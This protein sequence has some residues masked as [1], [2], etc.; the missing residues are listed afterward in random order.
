[1]IA[2][3][4]RAQLLSMRMGG[5][6]RA[7]SVVTGL[8]W[9]GVWVVAGCAVF[10][11]VSGASAD[12]LRLWLPLG[13]LG[14]CLYWQVMPILSASMGSALDMRKLMVYP[15]PHSK[16]FQ[17]EV[18][19]RLTTGVEM[20]MVLAGSVAGLFHRSPI[21]GCV[22]LPAVLL[23]IAFNLLL[24][25]GTRSLLERLLSMR[26]V[27][28][29]LVF[30]IFMVWMLPRFLFLTGHRPHLT[31]S[32][33]HLME[34]VAW[35]WTAAAW[36][37]LGHGELAALLSLGGWTL[38]A[39]WFGR[40][41]FERNLRFDAVAALATPQTNGASPVQAAAEAFYRFPARWLRDPLAA[42]V[43]KELRSLVRTPRYRMVFVMGFSFGLMIWLPMILGARADRNVTL[44]HHFLPVVS[45]YSLTLLGQVSFWNCFGFDR[46]AALIYFVAPQPLAKTFAGKNVAA[47]VFI[48]LEVFILAGVTSLFGVN[49]GVGQILETLLV[50]GICSL[51]MLA[52]GNI[53]S[54][55]YPRGLNP[56]RVSQGGASSRFQAL[57]M[58]LYPLSLL[59]VLLAYAARY[60]FASEVA[61]YLVLAFAAAVGGALYW[62][63]MESAV[64]TAFRH[65]ERIL[66][67]LSNAG[68]PVASD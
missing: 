52:L 43:E 9:Y 49:P 18:L 45:V 24:A 28:E 33:S 41:Q 35:P 7:F 50:V 58:L 6:G 15:V 61:F 64:A 62:I 19:L 55:Q 16:L 34:S 25:S 30:L 56:E 66:H 68:G 31:G 20:L 47:L 10:L 14:V 36:A 59:P 54:V 37:A 2:A 4:L 1:M 32:W 38:L 67:E 57:I 48:Y 29:L 46:S 17:V 5:R 22:S 13:A 3:I 51:Y 40:A 8:I 21:A 44:S 53:S 65:R 60:A 12:R 23:Y 26:K 11:G 39:G 42:I 27:R 63:A